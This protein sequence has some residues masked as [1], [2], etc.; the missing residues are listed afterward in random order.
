MNVQKPKARSGSLVRQSSAHALRRATLLLEVSRRCAQKSSLDG[1]FEVLVEM[2]SN[3]LNC[4]RGS[5]FLNDPVSGELFSR[6]AQ[7]KLT[8]EIRVLN[9][10]GVAGSVFQSGQPALVDDAY[11]DERFNSSVDERTG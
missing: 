6:V 8:R 1:I 9:S 7:G 10:S 11:A 5:L 4:D 2:T 3:A